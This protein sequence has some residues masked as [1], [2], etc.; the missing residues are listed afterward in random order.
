MREKPVVIQCEFASEGKD[1]SEILE[2]SFI[3]FLHRTFANPQG[4]AVQCPR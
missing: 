2:E 3:L 4:K 1:I